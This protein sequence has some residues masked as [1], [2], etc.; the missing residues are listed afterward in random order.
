MKICYFANA[1]SGHTIK[2]AKWFALRD[3]EIHILSLEKCNKNELKSIKNIHVHWLGCTSDRNGS[4]LQKLRYLLCIRKAKK[5]LSIIDP[6]IVHAHF[7][8]SYGFIC[9]LSCKAPFYLSVWGSDVYDFPRK[10]L[11]HKKLLQYAI[12]KCAWLLS[13][14]AAMAKEARQYTN[15]QIYVTPF[16]VDLDLFQYRQRSFNRSDAVFIIG[17]VKAL[18]SKYGI[19]CLLRA[20]SV[21][22]ETR[23]DIPLA[24]RI[25]GKGSKESELKS[26]GHELGLDN[27]LE[28][29]GFIPQQQAA[30][31]WQR[32]DAAIISSESESFGVSA[33]EAQACGC[34]VVISDIPGL[35]EACGGGSSALVV[36]RGDFKAFAKAIIDIYDNVD[37]ASHL[38]LAGRDNVALNYEVNHCFKRVNDLY[39]RN[40]KR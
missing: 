34:P 28:W 2:W 7:A 30:A 22:K 3:H 15:K 19:N 12:S 6:D 13:T 25:A 23:P 26:L 38:S 35:V 10:S 27:C 17:T 36:R 21:V 37:L 31:E 40:L 4:E 14:S 1:D 16:G 24:V 18:E 8:S 9:A 39:T 5:L 20:A 29:L 11:I 32:F 33:V